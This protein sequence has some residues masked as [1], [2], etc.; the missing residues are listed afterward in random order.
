MT[1]VPGASAGVNAEGHLHDL[2]SKS[3]ASA[4]VNKAPVAEKCPSPSLPLRSTLWVN[5]ALWNFGGDV[6]RTEGVPNKPLSRLS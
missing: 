3:H 1:L 5:S 2:P 6:R 4:G